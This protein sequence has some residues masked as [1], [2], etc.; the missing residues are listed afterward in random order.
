MQL[1]EGEDPLSV[2]LNGV[3]FWILIHDLPHGFLSESRRTRAWRSRSL[4]GDGGGGGGGSSNYGNSTNKY[5]TLIDQQAL[6]NRSVRRNEVYKLERSSG[7]LGRKGDPLSAYLFLICN[8]GLPT[9]LRMPSTSGDLKGNCIN[10]HVPLITHLLFAYDSLIFREVMMERARAL[11]DRLEIYANSSRQLIN[12][13]KSSTLFSSNNEGG[14]WFYD[15]SK[16]NIALLAE[17]GWR[18]MENLGSLTARLI[19]AKYYL[20]VLSSKKTAA[21]PLAWTASLDTCRRNK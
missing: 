7:L 5:Q 8:E 6:L 1:K 17:Q 12:F 18:L 9:L 4:V 11:K 16:F 13:N 2:R 21:L 19:R 3:D 14:M 15:L 20:L 10:R